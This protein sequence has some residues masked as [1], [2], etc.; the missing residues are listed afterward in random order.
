MNQ[1]LFWNFF[2]GI[3]FTLLIVAG[4][5][6]ASIAYPL[7][8]TGGSWST[9]YRRNYGVPRWRQDDHLRHL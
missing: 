4:P 8:A 9:A 5:V 6:I 3:C 1:F 2:V 7:I